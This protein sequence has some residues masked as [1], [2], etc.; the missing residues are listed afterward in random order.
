MSCRKLSNEF[1][2]RCKYP[3]LIAEVMETTFSICTI[4]EY[5]EL[6]RYRKEDDPEVWGML[7]GTIQMNVSNMMGLCR[8]F[9]MDPEYLFSNTLEVVNGKPLA[10]WRWY[11]RNQEQ[12][13][14]MEESRSLSKIYDT[15][16]NKRYLIGYVQ[17][18][19][20]YIERADDSIEA[21][22]NLVKTLK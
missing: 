13:R 1:F 18:V 7:N 6:G 2:S 5:M 20:D 21:A 14:Y 17:A 12:Q 22:Q 19:I 3:N 11:E 4:A 15:L 8:C 10:H 9:H 16:N